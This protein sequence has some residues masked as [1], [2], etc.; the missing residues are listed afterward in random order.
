MEAGYCDDF[1]PP[2]W[3]LGPLPSATQAHMVRA[4][5]MSE[6]C[7]EA[8]DLEDLVASLDLPSVEALEDRGALTLT[9]ASLAALLPAEHLEA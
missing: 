4:Q 8:Q 5:P 9:I 7:Q 3:V 2:S 6:E 1:G